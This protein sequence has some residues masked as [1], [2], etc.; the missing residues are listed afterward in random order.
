M[1]NVTPHQPSG[2]TK[3]CLFRPRRSRQSLLCFDSAERRSHSIR[4]TEWPSEISA[5]PDC[6]H[7]VYS[8]RHQSL[9]SSSWTIAQR[10]RSDNKGSTVAASSCQCLEVLLAATPSKSPPM[11]LGAWPILAKAP[12]EELVW[13]EAA[14]TITTSKGPNQIICFDMIFPTKSWGL[15]GI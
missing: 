5:V 9:S 15:S 3:R 2:V 6:R 4:R 11:K 1:I 12:L 10:G 7:H 13:V 8:G 14:T